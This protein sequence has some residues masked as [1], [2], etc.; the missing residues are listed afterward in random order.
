MMIRDDMTGLGIKLNQ[1]VTTELVMAGIEAFRR[2]KK[3]VDYASDWYIQT[4]DKEVIIA[5]SATDGFLSGCAN[6]NFSENKYRIFGWLECWFAMKNINPRD[7]EFNHYAGFSPFNRD[8]DY[9]HLGTGRV[10]QFFQTVESFG[11]WQSKTL[12]PMI[13]IQNWHGDTKLNKFYAAAEEYSD[14]VD[15]TEYVHYVNEDLN[16]HLY[17]GELNHVF[18]R[19]PREQVEQVLVMAV[20][21]YGPVNTKTWF[22][23]NKE[24]A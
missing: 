1:V 14:I 12:K 15:I 5:M 6:N 17:T 16:R 24:T 23:A 21:K 10:G 19:L 11:N 7:V 8:R 3:Y 20:L 13:E 9:K 22:Q 18:N 4:T 2:N